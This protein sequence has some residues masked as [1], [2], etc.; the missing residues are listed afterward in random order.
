[1]TSTNDN[2][3][4]VL[5]GNLSSEDENIAD[6][7]AEIGDYL[8]RIRSDG[9]SRLSDQDRA[10][11]CGEAAR[12]YNRVGQLEGERLLS[13]NLLKVLHQSNKPHDCAFERYQIA[14][15]AKEERLRLRNGHDSVDPRTEAIYR[16]SP[17]LGPR[18]VTVIQR[19]QLGEPPQRVSLEKQR[20]PGGY[21][22]STALRNL[23]SSD[24][25]ATRPLQGAGHD[26][27]AVHARALAERQAQ[28]QAH[29]RAQGH[30]QVRNDQVHLRRQWS[31]EQ[32]EAERIEQKPYPHLDYS[33]RSEEER[34]RDMRKERET[35]DVRRRAYN[36]SLARLPV[37]SR[38]LNSPTPHVD[39][40]RRDVDLEY[41]QNGQFSRWGNSRDSPQNLQQRNEAESFAHT[42]GV[43]VARQLQASAHTQSQ[44]FNRRGPTNLENW[45]DREMSI[46]REREPRFQPTFGAE[47]GPESMEKHSEATASA[48]AHRLSNS[49]RSLRSVSSVG[50]FETENRVTNGS[51]IDRK[52]SKLGDKHENT[53]GKS[54]EKHMPARK[55]SKLIEKNE[56]DEESDSA[57]NRKTADTISA[58][59]KAYVHKY[60]TTE[61]CA[62]KELAEGYVTTRAVRIVKR[63]ESLAQHLEFDYRA[64]KAHDYGTVEHSRALQNIIHKTKCGNKNDMPTLAALLHIKFCNDGHNPNHAHLQWSDQVRLIYSELFP[65][66]QINRAE[67]KSKS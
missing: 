31:Q 48:L 4:R 39:V 3:C 15:R 32:E 9:W 64:L 50:H 2:T 46:Q 65:A 18:D 60:L 57:R 37:S 62:H 66:K 1:M 23:R 5:T 14:V 40:D 25:A 34:E 59:D 19:A 38:D 43:P 29:S 11:M 49:D 17:P 7:R 41:N 16:S 56:G 21:S 67:D 6:Y 42:Q 13:L 55:R 27:Q 26:D 61:H 63:M 24:S 47:N 22:D 53:E 51:T 30:V 8:H 58:E 52:P 45:N 33:M 54:A 44:G 36:Q 10:A 35:E 12:N 20:S 28:A